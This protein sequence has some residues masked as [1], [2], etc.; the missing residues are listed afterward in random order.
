LGGLEAF[1]DGITVYVPGPLD[2]SVSYVP[3]GDGT[4][5]SDFATP[6]TDT[7]DNTTGVVVIPTA[8]GSVKLNSGFTVAP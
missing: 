5:S 6:T 2:T 7:L 4:I 3:L 8:G 1:S